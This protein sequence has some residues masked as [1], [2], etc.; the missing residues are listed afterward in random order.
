MLPQALIIILL[1][2]QPPIESSTDTI[3]VMDAR[4]VTVMAEPGSEARFTGVPSTSTVSVDELLTNGSAM[5]IRRAAMAGEAIVGGLRGGQVA[6]TIDGMKV[7]SACVDK[8][9]PATA[10]VELE[11]LSSLEM[12]S[13]ASDLRYGANLGGALT[14][15]MQTPQ[16]GDPLSMRADAWYD[17]NG[18][19]RTLKASGSGSTDETAMR[20]AYTYRASDDYRAGGGP[21]VSGSRYEK[22][23]A[24]A[25][26]AWQADEDHGLMLTGIYDL[27]TFIG[28]PALLM[29]TRR[30][31]AIIAGLT[32]TADW[33]SGLTSTTK[34]YA[35]RVDHVMDDY[36]RSVDEVNSRP[37]MPGMWMPMYG[38]TNTYGLLSEVRWS[39][40]A[41]SFL[42][43]VLDLSLLDAVATMDMVPLD[44]T[45]APMSM[46]N[47]GDARVGTIGLNA[48]WET[49]LPSDLTLRS[50]MRLD[51][52]P[53]TLRDPAARDILLAYVP[54]APIDRT[55][56]AVSASVGL[57]ASLADDLQGALTVSSLERLPTHLEAYGFWV[58]DPQANIVTIGDPGLNAERSWGL[59]VVLESQS[60]TLPFRLSGRTQIVTNYIAPGATVDASATPVRQIENIGTALLNGVDASIQYAA[61]QNLAIGAS[62]SWT[63]GTLLETNEPLP[64]IAP[65]TGM[66]RAIWS[67]ADWS[68]E[69]RLRGALQQ[70]RF[71]TT[72][73]PENATPSW[74]TMDLL[75]DWS[76]TSNVM[77]SAAL[78]NVLDARYHEH[79]SINDLPAPGRSFMIRV[80]TSW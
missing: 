73:L 69:A 35:N 29:D 76:V 78:R 51:V 8:M 6:L 52:S 68:I 55:Q 24:V 62:A 57:H 56:V 46:A 16:A 45:I 28:Y 42:S 80:R 58:F 48:T 17:A 36:S 4:T 53:R 49:L 20:A 63:H 25:S 9:D 33:A 7:H 22:H 60:S 54:G 38:T 70:Q 13:G 61:A 75:A 26:A 40:S 64:F 65:L 2:L 79:T 67:I 41:A 31:E 10:Y 72:I 71:S 32:W 43:M 21:L 18:N 11:N 15:R 59:N 14:F 74:V 27:A 3:G 39:P 66:V 47:I 1:G 30:A 77:L 5:L 19:G 23:N 44:T 12:S 37:F 50:T 34:L